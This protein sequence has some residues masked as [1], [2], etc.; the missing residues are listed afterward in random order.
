MTIRVAPASQRPATEISRFRVHRQDAAGEK[1]SCH[2]GHRA[3]FGRL[4]G[5]LLTQAFKGAKA[6]VAYVM[7]FSGSPAQVLRARGWDEFRAQHPEYDEV[8]R[9]TAG[10]IIA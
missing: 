10:D 8:A 6:K 3:V 1:R 4:Q 5:Q 9:V 7:G 2:G